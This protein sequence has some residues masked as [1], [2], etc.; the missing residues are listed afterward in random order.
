MCGILFVSCGKQN[1]PSEPL[2]LE[3]WRIGRLCRLY[4]QRNF[5]EL[6]TDFYAYRSCTKEELNQAVTLFELHAAECDSLQRYPVEV[7]YL[8]AELY[9][10]DS[11]A[12]VFVKKHYMDGTAE[13]VMFTMIYTE[14]DWYVR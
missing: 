2:P 10:G 14:D 5:E 1:T 9:P 4:T 13:E 6:L 11:I 8:R 3:D 12:D 7:E